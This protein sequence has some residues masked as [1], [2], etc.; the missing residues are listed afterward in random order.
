MMRN[1]IALILLTLSV[2]AFATNLKCEQLFHI[3]TRLSDAELDF[4]MMGGLSYITEGMGTLQR[5]NLHKLT[6]AIANQNLINKKNLQHQIAV[7]TSAVATTGKISINVALD[8]PQREVILSLGS[9]IKFQR[10]PETIATHL[11]RSI[12]VADTQGF[13]VKIKAMEAIEIRPVIMGFL[14]RSSDGSVHSEDFCK[15]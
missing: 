9:I 4:R 8:Q 5:L 15:T 7:D 3:D 10:D 6:W 11:N 2:P 14:R 1:L 12:D 13:S